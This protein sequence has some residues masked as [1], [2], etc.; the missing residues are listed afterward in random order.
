MGADVEIYLFDHNSYQRLVVPAYRAFFERH[1]SQPLV[2]LLQTVISKLDADTPL[3]T[4][5]LWTREIYLEALGIVEGKIYYNSKGQQ[6]SDSNSKTTRADLQLY[7][8]RNL[9]PTLTTPLCIPYKEGLVSN[10]DM[11]N[12]RLVD[13]LYEGSG[14][15]EDVFTFAKLLEGGSTEV[16][17]GES[18]ELFTKDEVQ[19]FSVELER[20]PEPDDTLLQD[21]LRNLRALV[22]LALSDPNLTLIRSII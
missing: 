12:S 10:Q 19:K 16:P 20:I 6:A 15:I 8:R 14:W 1:D 3:Y 2:Q 7:V 18:S 11:T 13:Y 5:P 9:G 4:S 17:I 21:E 22:Q